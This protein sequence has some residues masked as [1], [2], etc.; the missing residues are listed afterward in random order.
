MIQHVSRIC[1]TCG[2]PL[3]GRIDKKF[4]SDY[5][6]NTRNNMRKLENEAII[7]NINGSIRKNRFILKALC[8]EG[9]SIVRK[10]V[11]ENL[12]FRVDL[13]TTLYITSKKQI[14]YLCYDFG[15]T[16]ILEKGIQKVVIVSRQ[17]YMSAW[18]PWKYVK[19]N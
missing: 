15:F 16:P 17:P 5:C 14:Y 6:R 1:C 11:L 13:F 3:V 7:F 8:P 10:Q 12:G 9:K 2:A 19:K 18:D 4:C